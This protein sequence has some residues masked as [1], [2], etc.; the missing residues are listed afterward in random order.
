MGAGTLSNF[1]LAAGIVVNVVIT[2]LAIWWLL[3]QGMKQ[4]PPKDAPPDQS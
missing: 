3:R 4:P 1:F 2:A